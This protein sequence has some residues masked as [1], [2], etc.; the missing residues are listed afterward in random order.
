MAATLE[1]RLDS[2]MHEIRNI[3]KKLI[4]EK[5]A[6]ISVT[7]LRRST[8]KTLRKKVTA[9]WDQVS[10]LDEIRQQREKSW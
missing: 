2:L 7:K 3:K 1:H 10:A 6:R 4:L 5:V 9:R 8:W